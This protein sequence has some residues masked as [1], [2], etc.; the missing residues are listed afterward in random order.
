MKQLHLK[1]LPVFLCRYYTLYLLRHLG[2]KFR[3]DKPACANSV[4]SLFPLPN[5]LDERNEI[6]SPIDNSLTDFKLS[7]GKQLEGKKPHCELYNFS[8][9]FENYVHFEVTSSAMKI[10]SN[11]LNRFTICIHGSISLFCRNY[12]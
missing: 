10:F 11:Q 12:I 5:R 6:T 9:T 8:T 4:I 7:M 3:T 2:I 1:R